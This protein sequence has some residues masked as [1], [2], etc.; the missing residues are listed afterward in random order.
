MYCKNNLCSWR[1]PIYISTQ[2]ILSTQITEQIQHSYSNNTTETNNSKF[3]DKY[4]RFS[5]DI[6]SQGVQKE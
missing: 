2:S 1:R 4:N 3:N 5:T 6:G